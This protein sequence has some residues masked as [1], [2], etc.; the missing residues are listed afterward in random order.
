[1][2]KT[3]IC[4]EEGRN[5]YRTLYTYLN[6]VGADGFIVFSNE[7]DNRANVQYLSGFTGSTAVIVVGMT[8]A[9]LIVDSRYFEQADEESYIPVIRMS[10]RDPWDAIRQAAS[11][12][13]ISRI[14]FEEDRLSVK[15]HLLLQKAGLVT[16]PVPQIVMQI[17]GVKGFKEIATV[18]RASKIAAN[19]F[20]AIIPSLHIGMTERQMA[21][22]LANAVRE[23][24]ADK[25]VK[26]HFVVASG[27]R[28]CRPHGVFSDRVVEYGDM[29]TFDFGAV[30][31]GYVS[32]MTRTIAFGT[33]C[34]RMLDIYDAVLE[35]NKLAFESISY[36]VT[37]KALE[38]IV[39]GYL[40]KRG[41]SEYIKHSLGHGIGLELHELPNIN[42]ANHDMLP[43]GAIVTIEP[44]LYVPGLGG[45]RIEDAVLVTRD[46]YEVL[47]SDSPKELRILI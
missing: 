6:A 39:S 20:E 41:Y 2:L 12:L 17:R 18:R 42:K 25:L 26:G 33:P 40:G 31:D 36:K 35:A 13:S 11:G 21:A 22:L 15:R 3:I 27:L 23:R 5:R 14:A 45:V 24:G 28:G 32:D 9:Y 29:V 47:T 4:S 38:T 7:Y 10:G 1:M 19:S 46:G 30:I 43:I 37:G 16:I 44:G 8:G 34:E